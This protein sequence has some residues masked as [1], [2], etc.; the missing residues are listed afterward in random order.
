MPLAP[1]RPLLTQSGSD[2]PF[3]DSGLSLTQTRPFLSQSD[4]DLSFF[5]SRLAKLL[6]CNS[7]LE[8]L[9]SNFN[10]NFSS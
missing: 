9:L 10:L 6:K 4:S 3:T 7:S 8:L 2:L 1:A 5:E